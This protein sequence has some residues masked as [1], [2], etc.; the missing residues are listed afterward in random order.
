M[1]E[2][3][4]N[5]T[6]SDLEMTDSVVIINDTPGTET[7]NTLVN[8]E[9]LESVVS[10]LVTVDDKYQPER[11]FDNLVEKVIKDNI[12]LKYNNKN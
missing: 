3:F 1:N 7:G 9:Y 5:K 6:V 2:N 8:R 12:N 10:C 11:N 4:T